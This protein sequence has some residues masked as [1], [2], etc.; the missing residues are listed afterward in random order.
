MATMA[1]R[2]PAD[3]MRIRVGIARG[4]TALRTAHKTYSL[5]LGMPVLAKQ[6]NE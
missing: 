6:Q 3:Q 5:I 2:T 1:E 4:P